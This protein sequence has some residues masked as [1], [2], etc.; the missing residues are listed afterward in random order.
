MQSIK[1]KTTNFLAFNL[2]VLQVHIDK[3]IRKYCES[4]GMYSFEKINGNLD[5]LGLYRG[6]GLTP[7]IE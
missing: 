4:W 2:T 3:D 7:F 5:A 6:S 1:M